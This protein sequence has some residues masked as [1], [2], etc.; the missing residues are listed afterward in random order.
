MDAHCKHS[1]YRYVSTPFNSMDAHGLY[2]YGITPFNSMDAH[3]LYGCTPFNSMDA[4]GLYLYGCTPF[5][6]MEAWPLALWMHDL[7]LY[8]I[9]SW[10]PPL[11]V[12][13]FCYSLLSE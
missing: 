6:S 8:G 11:Q 7:H 2:L 5:I 3:D 10:A 4:H 9:Q 1:L 13:V 12:A